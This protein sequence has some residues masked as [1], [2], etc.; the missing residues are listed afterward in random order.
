MQCKLRT[1]KFYERTK[2]NAQRANGGVFLGFQPSIAYRRHEANLTKL[3]EHLI[4]TLYFK[5]IYTTVATINIRPKQPIPYELFQ[6]TSSNF[7]KYIIM[8][9]INYHSRTDR[10]KT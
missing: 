8:A 6:Y 7:R 9:D 3:P 10:Q 5:L 1:N 2:T 4:A